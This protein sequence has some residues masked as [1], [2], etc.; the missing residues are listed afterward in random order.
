MTICVFHLVGHKEYI[1]KCTDKEY[2]II[3]E[4]SFESPEVVR[5]LHRS[6]GQVGQTWHYVSRDICPDKVSSSDRTRYNLLPI[7]QQHDIVNIYPY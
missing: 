2:L 4:F 3:R 1:M 6:Q 5:L 7:K